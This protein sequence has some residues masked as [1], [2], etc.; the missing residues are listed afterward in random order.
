M[1]LVWL[2]ERTSH[3]Q[4]GK[5]NLLVDF[6]TSDINTHQSM[7]QQA[8]KLYRWQ[9]HVHECRA[10]TGILEFSSMLSL[11]AKCLLIKMS[12]QDEVQYWY[13]SN[14]IKLQEYG[15]HVNRF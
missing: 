15:C 6:S 10:L 7:N 1:L 11:V 4:R 13:S 9:S 14:I 8:L 3:L 5:I 2:L 12:A